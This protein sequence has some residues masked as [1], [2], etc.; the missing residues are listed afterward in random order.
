M[1]ESRITMT[2]VDLQMAGRRVRSRILD[3]RMLAHCPMVKMRMKWRA[4]WA[5]YDDINHFKIPKY[6]SYVAIVVE[7][8]YANVLSLQISEP[9][10]EINIAVIGA[11]GV[12]KSTFVQKAFDLP[13]LPPSQ[14]AERKIP[15]NEDV[16]LVRL[17][18]LPI[19]DVDIDDDDTVTWP[20][21]IEDKVMPRID[22]AITLYDVQDKDTFDD[23]PEVLSES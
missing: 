3:R 15:V 17:L 1:S 11:E 22:G 18:E 21:T 10:P 7:M 19:E 9:L 2:G 8:R 12:G 23:I 6:G 20:D 4:W 13:H 14:A 16:Y 5:L